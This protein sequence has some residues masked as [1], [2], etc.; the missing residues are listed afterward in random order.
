MENYIEGRVVL[1]VLCLIH[2]FLSYASVGPW[3]HIKGKVLDGIFLTELIAVTAYIIY[4]NVQ[5]PPYDGWF[6]A[7]IGYLFVYAMI[8]MTWLMYG[9]FALLEEDKVYEMT[10][11]HHVHLMNERYFQGTV[12]NGKYE[13]QVYLPYSSEL[14]SL[15][16]DNYKLNVKFDRIIR[17]MYIVVKCV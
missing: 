1:G 11:T 5:T 2:L 16:E 13:H 10:I 9:V 12:I 4:D 8:F 6:W 14:H 7:I 15:I 3:G 17:G